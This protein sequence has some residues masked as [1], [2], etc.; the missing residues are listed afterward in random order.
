MAIIALLLSAA[1]V[2]VDQIIKLLVTANLKPDSGFTVINGIF[3]IFYIKNKGAAFGIL[4]NQRWFFIAVTLAIS[5]LLIISLFQYKDHTVYSYIAVIL[6]VGG[7]LGNLIDRVV[8]GYVIDYL[9]FSFFPPIFN[10]ADCCVTVGTVFL[11]IHIL[12]FSNLDSN[13][14]RVIRRK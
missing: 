4:Q 8:H 7:G 11:I 12:F 3:N 6:I 9:S 2:V 10:F 5:I 1:A 13:A 14:E